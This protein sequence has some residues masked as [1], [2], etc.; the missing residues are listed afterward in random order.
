MAVDPGP[1]P[2][3]R[4]VK[5]HCCNYVHVNM[6]QFHH[7]NFSF[8]SNIKHGARKLGLACAGVSN[9][10]NSSTIFEI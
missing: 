3:L 9:E 2:R 7:K 1:K 10:T 5:V 6:R 8:P 4:S